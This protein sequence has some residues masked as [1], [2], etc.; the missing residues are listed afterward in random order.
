MA[1]ARDLPG[2][3]RPR[4]RHD[5]LLDPLVVWFDNQHV[6]LAELGYEGV[7]PD[8]KATYDAPR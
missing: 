7:A 5:G 8:H 2:T 3:A 1:A 4:T 6:V